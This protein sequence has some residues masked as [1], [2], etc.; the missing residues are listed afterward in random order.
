VPKKREERAS[1]PAQTLVVLLE[2]AA[3]L[4]M[5]EVLLDA[6]FGFMVADLR[7]G[8]GYEN[9]RKRLFV[10]LIDGEKEGE[11]EAVVGRWEKENTRHIFV[12]EDYSLHE[13]RWITEEDDDISILQREL[14][15]QCRIR[16]G[17]MKERPALPAVGTAALSRAGAELS[18]KRWGK[19]E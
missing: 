14:H 8:R 11:L 19:E 7:V 12:E 6:G 2:G 18:R 15:V 1:R 3:H 9:G 17:F 16:P 4:A 5:H 13:W 10:D